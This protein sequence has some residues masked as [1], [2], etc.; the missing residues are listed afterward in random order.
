MYVNVSLYYRVLHIAV[1]DKHSDIVFMLQC[2]RLVPLR[3]L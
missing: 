3:D 2:A 1:I